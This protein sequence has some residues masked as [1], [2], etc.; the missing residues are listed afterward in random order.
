M[1][2]DVKIPEVGE[3]ITEG[4]LVEWTSPDGATV[5]ADDALLVLETDKITMNVVAETGGRLEILVPAGETV[6]VGQV[7]GRIDTDAAGDAPS[8]APAPVPAAEPAAAVAAT[9]SADV[10]GLSPAV[11]RLVEE[12]GLDPAAIEGTGRAGR[13]LKGDV[14]A[15]LERRQDAGPVPAPAREEAPVA[16]AAP[17]R[18]PVPPSRPQP[19]P[20]PGLRQSRQPM[21][22]L[23]QRL[24]ER[25]VEVQRT[26]AMLTTFNEV[27]MSRVMAL[28]ERYQDRFVERHGVKLGF[29]S[30]FVKAVV[31]ALKAVPEVNAFIE[32]NEIVTN[33]YFDIGIAVS[34][35]H[36]LVV[37]VVRDADRLSM[38]GIEL[39][40]AELAG[41]ARNRT[42]EL[43][44]LSGA[45][46]TITNGGIF[47]SLLSTPILNPP[48][49]AILGM[50]AIK[51]RPVAVDGQ[52]VIRPMMNLAVSYDHRLI[53][54]KEAVTFLKRIVDDLSDP[55]RLLLE[56]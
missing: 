45:V 32:G 35:E 24:A 36:G 42:L 26:T 31:D 17:A 49:S 33:H 16:A 46:F 28:R 1:P 8:K 43:A 51:E 15:H 56:I 18:F 5:A 22:R 21:S 39:A 34:S 9:P 7:V 2:V 41:K 50:H 6:R 10:S 12:H 54:G 20:S 38:A 55:E 25:L 48:G 11:R 29:M 14:L 53:D 4:F 40:I 3:S 37:P 27:D 52:V 30:F 44:D 13:I 47:G 23:R 19:G